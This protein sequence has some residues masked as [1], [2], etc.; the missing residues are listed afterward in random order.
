MPKSSNQKL[1]LLYLLK[2]LREETDEEH[3]LN[4]QQ[5]IERLARWDISAERKSIYDDIARL[6]DFGYDIV[7]VKIRP[8]A[9]TIW[10][11]GNL[12]FLS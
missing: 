2:I 4:S 10:V 5:L 8:A 6:M 12:S 1:K 9:A 3:F 7:H 11:P